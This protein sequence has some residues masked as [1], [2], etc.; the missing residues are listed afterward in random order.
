MVN[1]S[2]GSWTAAPARLNT[3]VPVV[4]L[5]P[6]DVDDTV[7]LLARPVVVTAI[8]SPPI[9]LTHTFLSVRPRRIESVSHAWLS[10]GSSSM[11][12]PGGAIVA[13]FCTDA[14]T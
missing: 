13:Q 3:C 14:A 9:A 6:V 11:T 7:A 4:V 1:P 5:L 2:A 12:E 10:C 8:A